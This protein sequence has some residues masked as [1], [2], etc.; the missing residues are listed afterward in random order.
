[1]EGHRLRT[2]ASSGLADLVSK[3]TLGEQFGVRAGQKLRK[4]AV[5]LLRLQDNLVTDHDAGFV[6]RKE[7]LLGG[8]VSFLRLRLLFLLL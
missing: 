6:G 1:M 3:G 2:T 7:Q 4:R 8:T 5:G